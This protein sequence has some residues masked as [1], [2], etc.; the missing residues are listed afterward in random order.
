MT[1]SI[2]VIAFVIIHAIYVDWHRKN[3]LR[4]MQRDLLIHT[5]RYDALYRSMCNIQE[6][7][8]IGEAHAVAKAAL[9]A[10]DVNEDG[11]LNED[12][13]SGISKPVPRTDYL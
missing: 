4:D 11:S 13:Y 10:H 9:G 1:L 3:E 7:N 6:C 2:I 5:A 12:G 8:T